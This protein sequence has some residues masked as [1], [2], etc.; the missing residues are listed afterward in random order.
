M[1]ANLDNGVILGALGSLHTDGTGAVVPP[2]GMV[3]AA[4][5]F[6]TKN[7]PTALV[8][9]NPDKTFSIAHAAHSKGAGSETVDEGSGGVQMSGCEFP[10]GMTIYGRWTTATFEGD[11]DGGVIC[12]FGY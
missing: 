11:S 5:Q 7:K 8:A 10:A 3:I 2:T 4:I 6:I 12:Y 9:E 1:A